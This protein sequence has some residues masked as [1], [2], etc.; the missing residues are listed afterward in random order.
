MDSCEGVTMPGETAWENTVAEARYLKICHFMGNYEQI[1]FGLLGQPW[2]ACGGQWAV[3]HTLDHL[4]C[5]WRKTA[6]IEMR[7]R[8]RVRWGL[9]FVVLYHTWETDAPWSERN[10]WSSNMTAR[11]LPT[12]AGVKKWRGNLAVDIHPCSVQSPF[13][14]VIAP[15]NMFSGFLTDIQVTEDRAS[16]PL[17]SFQVSK[18]S[19]VSHKAEVP[20]YRVCQHWFWDST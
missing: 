8:V 19:R 6:V 10:S 17:F 20:S 18:K 3:C 9:I 2:A 11:F 12:W 7:E 15:T 16:K 5:A 13:P 14:T 4:Q 1:A